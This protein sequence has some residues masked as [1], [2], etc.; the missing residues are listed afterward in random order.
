MLRMDEFNK[1]RKEFYINGKS[2]YKIAREYRRS[3]ATVK[4]IVAMPEHKIT[5]RGKRPNKSPIVITPDIEQRI[6]D[7]L[8]FE[9]IHRVPKKQRFTAAYI[10]KKLKEETIYQG[11]AKRLRTVVSQ[12]RKER[13]LCKNKSYLSLDFKFGDHSNVIFHIGMIDIKS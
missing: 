4:A 3:W 9:E 13:K 11:S 2:M 8:D 10:F 12:I 6:H 7:F 1:I 5:Q